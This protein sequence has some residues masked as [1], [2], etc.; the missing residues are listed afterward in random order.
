[1]VSGIITKDCLSKSNV[2]PCE[3]CTSGVAKA[4][5]V[6]CVQCGMLIHGRIAGVKWVT[7]MCSK[8]M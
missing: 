8:N 2:H 6:L 3:V 5:S 1:M 4:N 7:S